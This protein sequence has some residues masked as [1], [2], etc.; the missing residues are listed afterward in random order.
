MLTLY[1]RH[2]KDCASTDRYYKRCKCP[3]WAE[4]TVEG[5]YLRSSLKTRSW[6]R[7]EELKREMERGVSVQLDLSEAID[8]FMAN[9]RALHRSPDTI[10]KND[11]LLQNLEIAL[12]GKLSRITLDDL[13]TFRESWKVGPLT[14]YKQT[15]RLKSFFRFC[16]LSGWIQTNPAAFIQNPIP[17]P[18]PTLPFKESEWQAIV[19]ALDKYPDNYGRTGQENAVRLKALVYTLRYSGLRIRDVVTLQR[20]SLIA[21]KLFLRT[22]KTGV[23]VWIPLPPEVSIMLQFCPGNRTFFFWSGES[24][25]KSAVSDWQRSLRK[26][27]TLAKVKGHAHMFRDTFAV[28]LLESGVPMEEVSTLLGHSS[29][30]IT[31]KYYAPYTKGRQDRLEELVRRTFPKLIRVK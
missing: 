28:S 9:L 16:H 17:K 2:T 13:R 18:N 21:D 25:P 12:K 11:R 15:E 30:R 24:N 7:A 23:K 26:L 8:R 5:K 29:I 20:E 19:K 6:E 31:E 10:T 4:G 27:F 22:S 14:S 1:R 3:M